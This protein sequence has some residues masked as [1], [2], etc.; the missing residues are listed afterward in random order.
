MCAGS[1]KKYG[2]LEAPY[3]LVVPELQFRG[4]VGGRL[5]GLRRLGDGDSGPVEVRK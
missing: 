2:G 5:R 1:K 3:L 4:G